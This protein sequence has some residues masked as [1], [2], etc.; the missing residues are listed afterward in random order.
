MLWTSRAP[1]GG[2]KQIVRQMADAVL[3]FYNSEFIF[4]YKKEIESWKSSSRESNPDR[5]VERPDSIP[6]DQGGLMKQWRV[7]IILSYIHLTRSTKVSCRDEN[8][9][10]GCYKRPGLFA[11]R[12]CCRMNVSLEWLES[13]HQGR[14]YS[15]TLPPACGR[16]QGYRI[17]PCPFGDF[18]VTPRRHNQYLILFFK[19]ICL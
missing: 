8:R 1:K 5:L 13:L 11:P 18:L 19:S 9:R 17:M 2:E 12:N 6:L 14:A 4:N 10:H 3:C 15:V 16:Q 7:L